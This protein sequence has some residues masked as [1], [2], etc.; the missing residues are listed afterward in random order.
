MQDSRPPERL[1]SW[2]I[3][4]KSLNLWRANLRSQLHISLIW[5][6]LPQFALLLISSRLALTT[7]NRLWDVTSQ[8]NGFNN[9]T[10]DTLLA[11]LNSFIAPFG[12]L[13]L[14]SLI[15]FCIGYGAL[16]YSNIKTKVSEDGSKNHQAPEVNESVRFGLKSSLKILGISIALQFIFLIGIQLVIFHMIALVLGA[17]APVILMVEKKGVFKSI[18]SSLFMKYADKKN[19]GA[20]SLFFSL[21]GASALVYLLST[22]LLEIIL[23][24]SLLDISLGLPRAMFVSGSIAGIPL[25]KILT[26]LL[27]SVALGMI[28]SFV[29]CL[30]VSFYNLSRK[31]LN[32]YL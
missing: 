6:V 27:S 11:Q 8:N 21:A 1:S 2:T 18:S 15:C 29:S 19:Q 23:Q 24:F 13:W 30:T 4:S 28:I 7:S 3:L 10:L 12:L 5:L 9:V 26:F 31:R 22:A 14:S 16:T 32:A 20:V 25:A 17:L